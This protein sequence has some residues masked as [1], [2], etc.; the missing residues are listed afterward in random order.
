MLVIVIQSE[1]F[2]AKNPDA[3]VFRSYRPQSTTTYDPKPQLCLV[4]FPLGKGPGVRSIA[5]ATSRLLRQK[6]SHNLRELGRLLQLRKMTTAID[7]LEA[8]AVYGLPIQVAAFERH[9]KYLRAELAHRINLKFAPDIRFRVDDRFDEA[10]RIEKLLRK[11]AVQRD[12][13]PDSD[14]DR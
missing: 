8:R 10:E 12:I 9:K 11:P 13:A 4:P 5:P 2:G 7:H 14:E 6:L 3:R 1:V